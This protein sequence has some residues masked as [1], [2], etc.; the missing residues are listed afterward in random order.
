LTSTSI[1][2]TKHNQ[3]SLNDYLQ[4]FSNPSYINEGIC[5]DVEHGFFHSFNYYNEVVSQLV[6]VGEDG[7]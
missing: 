2:L 6:Y 1:H 7:A 5:Y 4:F 3:Y